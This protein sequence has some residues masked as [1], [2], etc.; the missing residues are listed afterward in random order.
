LPGATG[1]VDDARCFAFRQE[2]FEGLRD[3]ERTDGVRGKSL[4]RGI[5]VEIED[6]AAIVEENRG[7]VDER[8]EM[9]RLP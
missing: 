4:Q 1:N 7:V 3:E 6:A 9:V 2:R 8:I 5:P